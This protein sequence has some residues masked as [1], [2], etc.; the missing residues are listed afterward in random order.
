M[1]WSDTTGEAVFRADVRALIEQSLPRRYRELAKLPH[2]PERVW[3][4]D[5]ASGNPEQVQASQE[6][7]QALSA[8]GWVAPH[9]PSEYGGAGLSPTEQFIFNQELASAAAPTCGITGV[10]LLG[11]TPVVHGT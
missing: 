10:A 2:L 5:R 3:E 9:W 6:W 4:F 7:V 8:R 11:P 1:D